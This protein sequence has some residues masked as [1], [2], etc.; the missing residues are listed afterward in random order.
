MGKFAEIKHKILAENGVDPTKF[1]L[2]DDGDLQ[3][4]PDESAATAGFKSAAYNAPRTALGFA[5]AAL[6]A[7][8]GGALG[9]LGGPAAPV[10]VP[11]G[12]ISGAL[13]GSAVGSKLGE[14][15]QDAAYPED[16]K[17]AQEA[18]AARHPTATFAADVGSSALLMRPSPKMLSTVL[19][20]PAEFIRAGG[21]VSPATRAALLET[22]LGGAIEAGSTL[23]QGG[24]AGD[25]GLSA[26]I[27]AV[28]SQP[29]RLGQLM[30][31]GVFT[32]WQPGP[33]IAD[34][35]ASVVDSLAQRREAV[36][37]AIRSAEAQ[38]VKSGQEGPPMPE[39]TTFG[40]P[41]E[42]EL[43]AVPTEGWNKF[44]AEF[45]P[46]LKAQFNLRPE[47]VGPGGAEAAGSVD[48]RT[49]PSAEAQINVS[50]KGYLDTAPHEATHLFIDDILNHGNPRERRFLETALQQLGLEVEEVG[51]KRRVRGLDAEEGAVQSLGED[52]T[53]RVAQR[54]VPVL[55]ALRDFA[56]YYMRSRMTPES[57]RRM[58]SGR[59]LHGRGT[60]PALD[61]KAGA[62]ATPEP[63]E[64]PPPV[65]PPVQPEP[66]TAP[67]AQPTRVVT[68][69]EAERLQT[70]R[71]RARRATDLEAAFAER[72]A[73]EAEQRLRA[74]IEALPESPEKARRRAELEAGLPKPDRAADFERAQ[75]EL[76][77]QSGVEVG[78]AVARPE[79]RNI[80]GSG[81]AR[82]MQQQKANKQNER[83]SAE[84][85]EM[86]RLEDRL[87]GRDRSRYQ[88]LGPDR[89]FATDFEK[90]LANPRPFKVQVAKDGRMSAND[91]RS[92]VARL[93]PTEQELLRAGGL[94]EYLRKVVRPSPAELQAWAAENLPQL[95]VK[96]LGAIGADTSELER[97]VAKLKHELETE[98]STE[99][100]NYIRHSLV[101]SRYAALY[102]VSADIKD[103]ARSEA[104]E[105]KV[106]EYEDARQ[107]ASDVKDYGPANENDSATRRY[108]GAGVNPRQLAD[109][110]GA[111]DLLV[112]VPS[113]NL[114]YE[115]FLQSGGREDSPNARAIY[116]SASNANRSG[117]AK[118][119]ALYSSSHYPQSGDNLLAHLRAYEHTMPDGERVLRV[120]EV[121]SDWAQGRRKDLSG[122]EVYQEPNQ[123]W[124]V[125]NEKKRDSAG[126]FKTE[127]DARSYIEKQIR[128]SNYPLLAHHQRLALKAAIEHARKR[129]IKKIVVDDAETAMLTEGHDKYAKSALRDGTYTVKWNGEQKTVTI[130]NN[131]A[132]G[133]LAE[134]DYWNKILDNGSTRLELIRDQL[135]VDR[136]VSQER[137]MRLAY[138]NVLQQMMRD[139]AGEGVRVELGEHR[140]V[141]EG[142]AQDHSDQPSRVRPDLVFRNPDGTPKTQSTGFAYDVSAPQARRDAGEPF[143]VA[144]RRYQ[145]LGP[146]N[147]NLNAWRRSAEPRRAFH[148]GSF[149]AEGAFRLG[150]GVFGKGIYF[151]SNKAIAEMYRKQRGG[152]EPIEGG[153]TDEYEIR[154][155][156]P[157]IVKET[158]WPEAAVFEAL[159]LSRSKAEAKA[160]KLIEDKGALGNSVKTLAQ[161]QGY[162][163]IIYERKNGSK[164]Y[165]LF[166]SNQAKL[167]VGNNGE[168]SD[169]PDVRYQPLGPTHGS[170]G[171][172]K[173]P[174][175]EQ[176]RRGIFAG[177]VEA[178]RRSKHPGKAYF[179]DRAV[180]LYAKI[181][182]NIG[183]YEEATLRP[184]LDLKPADR[185]ALVELMYEEDQLGKP[186]RS[187]LAARIQPAYDAV[188]AGLKLMRTDQNAAN[189]LIDGM[190]AKID[191]T[192]FPNIID[193]AVL[194][195]LS[196]NKGTPRYNALRKQ[197]VDYNTQ[198]FE[199]KYKMTALDA[200]AKAEELFGQ[201]SGTL[202]PASIEGGFDFGPVTLRANSKLPP[203]WVAE[204]PVAGFRTYIKRFSR[205]RAFYDTVQRDERTMQL[206]GSGHY[207]DA[208]GAKQ[209]TTPD[210]IATDPNVR[211]LLEDAIG[212]THESQE[213][214]TPAIGRLANSLL[215]S[216]LAT[217]MTDAATTPFKMLAYIPASA[218]PGYVGHLANIRQ[219]IQNAYSTGGV[220]RGDMMVMRD[221][222]GA[223]DGI[224]HGLDRASQFITKWTGSELLEKGARFVAQSAGEYV[225]DVN[226]A[227]A[228]KGDKRAL[229][230]FQRLTPQWR[231]LPRAEVSQRIAQLFQGSYDA[232]NLPIWIKN[233]PAAPFFSM[234]KWNVEQWN[235]FKRFAWQPLTKGDAVPMI[236]TLLGG[237]LGGAV[238]GELREEIT[239][240]KQRV[241]EFAELQDALANGA[242]GPA[243]QEFMRKLA[244]LSQVTG[245]LGVVGEVNL[246]VM[247]ILAKDKPQGFSWPAYELAR[248]VVDSTAN[249]GQAI[250]KRPEDALLITGTWA[251]NL[252]KTVFSQYR[253]AMN[254]V[255]RATGGA[256]AE[257]LA[258]DS[259][260]ES[261]RRRD[262]RVSERMRGEEIRK[263]PY[264]EQDL[265]NVRERAFDRA[266][267]PAEIITEAQAL[268]RQ[269]LR[270]AR[271]PEEYEAARRKFR[272][273]RIAGVPSF[274]NDPAKFMAHLDFVRRTQGEE[275]ERKLRLEYARLRALQKFR[276]ELF[277]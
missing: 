12:A 62:A 46:R 82:S 75:G 265:A 70:A 165:V 261:N 221:I 103:K 88:P 136:V 159:G 276:S 44:W 262:L 86:R 65:E 232:T 243:A 224:G 102:K 83:E 94:D 141:R 242:T 140:N 123:R 171:G 272:A 11:G 73:A 235:N 9:A 223:G 271:T 248:T 106:S 216:N 267:E 116:E 127:Q 89:V 204:D 56:D 20:S 218:V 84:D 66:P 187:R 10:T 34:A 154:L 29:T 98:Y 135:P 260:A 270:E 157:L 194:H 252:A 208:A 264:I 134:Q 77:V 85:L 225:Y 58:L 189:H 121:Q 105:S 167:V 63:T 205:A 268:Q 133:P 255:D 209:E 39:P 231:T 210:S 71:E 114:T 35:R 142:G 186:L 203:T 54:D 13:A 18:R 181:R 229:D 4:L 145:P 100:S 179:A 233:S 146:D 227:L 254:A 257:V 237:L 191:P 43:G 25:V 111:V 277:K 76:A 61:G 258:S 113:K 67:P 220:R 119:P 219:S 152:Y 64:P 115:E 176:P 72:D 93:N 8:G 26:L 197:F 175:R 36:L 107:E 247:D 174:P 249:A 198:H 40:S 228:L 161:K 112:R 251:N 222:L 131:R 101:Q 120:F 132:D 95:E 212:V 118:A 27:G 241:A 96:E 234:L 109:M 41:I 7:K 214:I 269:A 24:S 33:S 21:Q 188:R 22:G 117:M 50:E 266:D 104:F 97:K 168:Y 215:L 172:A 263:T 110:P 53:R 178:L 169:S 59:I 128:T 201:F 151:S 275:A 166:E 80:D 245:T 68:S 78:S 130:K 124:A 143:T 160:E 6:G 162:D 52:I 156:K 207:Y 129:G 81:F 182:A 16:W 17:L 51:G 55:D 99:F 108:D 57:A 193:P 23:A 49:A 177:N 202:K 273:Q 239:G 15:L 238:V 164:E 90:E 126:G 163:G 19:R 230:F 195:D 148:G 246:Q 149:P 45:M 30:S 200:R 183:K 92:A 184:L 137:G 199:K 196:Y 28:N 1:W 274:D 14:F 253:V 211:V 256:S 139:M 236:R 158:N 87:A 38:R 170:Y 60:A 32:P 240:K 74:S 2:T 226:R 5:G 48:M 190:P 180:E 155:T 69:G 192:Y 144:G 217:R 42:E 3:A 79:E 259:L 173:L 122:W 153:R 206:I 91:V 47:V 213:A 150:D 37:E 31:R 138:D 250:A 244:F 185:K 147:E 125:K